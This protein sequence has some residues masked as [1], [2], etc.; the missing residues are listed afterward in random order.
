MPAEQRAQFPYQ[1]M[2]TDLRQKIDSGELRGQIPTRAALEEQYEVSHM[3]VDRVLRL[4]KDD[5]LIY[6]V[7]GLGA[8][9]NE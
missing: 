9:T 1:R 6:S 5:G 3:V 8:F 4:L 7:P 2:L